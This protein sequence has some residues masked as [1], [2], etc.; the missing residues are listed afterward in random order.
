MFVRRRFLVPCHP[1]AYTPKD[2]GVT[3]I[4]DDLVTV[5]REAAGL[6]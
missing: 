2:F 5:V 4:V 1:E 6:A 3:A